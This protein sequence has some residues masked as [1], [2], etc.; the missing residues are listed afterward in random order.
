MG[1]DMHQLLQHTVLLDGWLVML[2]HSFIV[3]PVSMY[4]VSMCVGYG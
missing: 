3:V 4:W 2:V 1:Y